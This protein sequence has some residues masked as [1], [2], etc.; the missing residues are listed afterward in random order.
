MGVLTLFGRRG[1]APGNDR[2]RAAC[3]RCAMTGYRPVRP[4]AFAGL[5][6]EDWPWS[7]AASLRKITLCRSPDEKRT[8]SIG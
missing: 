3:I 7:A 8:T 5:T 2:C 6:V 1:G 4:N